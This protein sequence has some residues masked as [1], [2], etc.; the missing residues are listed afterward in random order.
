MIIIY[1]ND[2]IERASLGSC[3][4]DR[5]ALNQTFE[6][7]EIDD[8]YNK[9]HQII[10]QTI[11]EMVRL[12]VGID[13]IIL[14]EKLQSKGQL[15]KIGGV[16]YLTKIISSV[17]TFKN[18]E[19]YNSIIKKNS[20]QRKIKEIL[21]DLKME[22]VA[23]PEA[24]EL[25]AKVP[26]VEVKEETLKT[27]LKNTILISSKGVAHRY[28]IPSLNHYL[29]GIDKGE[30]VTIGG[31]TS[32]GKTSLAV[33]LAI[34]FI[35]INEDKKV[36]YLTSEM[37]APETAR[38]ILANLMPKNVMELRKGLIEPEE[39]KALD[40]IAE[41]IG[42]HWNLNIKKVFNVEDIKRCVRKYEPE[43]VFV[44]YLHNLSRKMSR[45]DYE[46]VSM[47]IRD[48]QA[49]AIDKEISIIVLSQ[50]SRDKTIIRKPRITD[51]RGSGRI[52]EC[53]NVVILAYWENRIK[54]KNKMRKGG[55]PPEKLELSIV[56]NKDG[57][58]G[59]LT[60]NFEP[61]YCR[62]REPVWEG[63]NEYER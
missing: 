55:E 63:R 31:F 39:R 49:L 4:L 44:D 20:N 62:V 53:S 26:V 2:E 25:I 5:E 8:F 57:T 16:V 32:Q 24:L 13:M 11:M 15:E 45:S 61:E 50:L 30:I 17:P 10:F 46:A 23:I 51:L 3:L 34:D 47:N 38:R 1:N 22:N 9:A 58:I 52:E 36:L 12:N 18:I 28:K 54:L 29:G 37:T 35:D 6:C 42:E 43:I 48:L 7:L 41:L 56:K 60:L 14:T 40:S 19:H 27:L 59:K 21:Q 33:Q